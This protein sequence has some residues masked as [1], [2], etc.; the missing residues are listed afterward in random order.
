MDPSVN[1]DQTNTTPATDGSNAGVAPV[2]P[3]PVTTPA[4]DTTDFAGVD[5]TSDST[6]AVEPVSLSP[7]EPVTPPATDGPEPADS[8]VPDPNAAP[9]VSAQSDQPDVPVGGAF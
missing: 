3:T 9:E 1:S 2:T 6:P 8:P 7:V 5:A 4:A